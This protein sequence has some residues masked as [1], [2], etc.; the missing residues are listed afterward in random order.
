MALSAAEQ[1]EAEFLTVPVNN[2]EPLGEEFRDLDVEALFAAH[3]GPPPSS[4]KP[5]WRVK[6]SLTMTERTCSACRTRERPRAWLSG[7]H[8]GFTSK[9]AKLPTAVSGFGISL[10]RPCCTPAGIKLGLQNRAQDFTETQSSKRGSENTTGKERSHMSPAAAS[11]QTSAI[12]LEQIRE[13][14]HNHRK[15]FDE[16]KLQELADSVKEHGVLQPVLVRPAPPPISGKVKYELVHGHRR[17]RA[18]RLA[19]LKEIPAAVRQLDDKAALELSILENL[20]R[21]DVLPIEEAEGYQ[22]LHEKHKVSVEELARRVGKSPEY[23]YGRMKLCALKSAAMRK[24]LDEGK[25]PPST[26][27]LVARIPGQKLQEQAAKKILEGGAYGDD[28]KPTP[29]SYRSAKE[30]V[31]EAYMLQLSKAPFNPKDAKLVPEAGA[32]G[33]C[34]KRTGNCKV[35]F[36]DVKGE[37]VCTDPE[38]F[39]KKKAAAFKLAK[40]EAAAKGQKLLP[41]NK[42][43]WDWEG[44]RLG[45]SGQ[46][47]YVELNATA[48]GDKKKRT[49]KDLLGDKAEV[50]LA[51]D[52]NG[53]VHHLLKRDGLA[54]ALKEVGFTPKE[55]QDRGGGGFDREAHERRAQEHDFR[56]RVVDRL[57]N[58]VVSGLAVRGAVKPDEA[59]RLLAT[60]LY[61]PHEAGSWKEHLEA[62]DVKAFLAQASLSEALAVVFGVCA[63]DALS[64]VWNGYA[65]GTEAAC[66]LVGMTLKDLEKE[67]KEADAAAAP[68]KEAKPGQAEQPAEEDGEES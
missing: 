29:M 30:F 3:F 57:V 45:H 16:A 54:E 15:Y 19:K 17:F 26:A 35:L 4:E 21:Q 49:F 38:C 9:T 34:P 51:R 33:P 42:N 12:P 64:T 68:A 43:L 50:L 8:L 24:A 20:Q 37:N 63:T 25:V 31:L 61:G 18:A 40:E 55:R 46:E 11:L 39:N 5:I 41:D 48:P 44:K 58:K 23:V 22:E 1:R 13:S 14:P 27:L 47:K 53:K 65:L 60:L 2:G 59:M 67:Q 56:E 62:D 28:L 36:P 32:C 10:C 7:E 6:A 52:P 66:A